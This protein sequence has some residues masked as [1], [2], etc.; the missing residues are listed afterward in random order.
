[1]ITIT[2]TRADHSEPDYPPHWVP[3][4]LDQPL[5]RE[6][7][8]LGDPPIYF[9]DLVVS[10]QVGFLGSPET[11]LL[12]ADNRGSRSPRRRF[13]PQRTSTLSP[14]SWCGTTSPGTPNHNWL[15]NS[16]S[17]WGPSE[18]TGVPGGHAAP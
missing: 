13:A 12:A 15:R 14:T 17:S 7:L 6:R 2:A 10:H 1:M 18:S 11:A 16:P 9:R 8:T 4:K 3:F 5:F